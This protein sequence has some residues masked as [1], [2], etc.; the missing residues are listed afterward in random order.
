MLY[1]TK[2]PHG[3]DI[4]DSPVE[5]DYSANINPFGTP[6]AVKRAMAD[7]LEQVVHYPDPY[8][9]KLVAAISAHEGV[10][11]SYILCGNG[12]AELIYS[13][14]EAV[15]ARRALETAPTFSEYSLALEKTGCEVL[16]YELGEED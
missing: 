3:G 8:C 11:E 2:N 1:N 12:A 10:P 9:R 14:A 7:A 16:R 5:L 15:H 13:Y 4:Y 6:P